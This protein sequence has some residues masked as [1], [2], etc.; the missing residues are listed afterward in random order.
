MVFGAKTVAQLVKQVTD[1]ASMTK[2]EAAGNASIRM[3]SAEALE[4]LCEALKTHKC[5]KQVVLSE[6]EITDDGC[7]FLAQLLKEN[8]VIEELVLDKNKIQSAGAK[9]LADALTKNQGLR[10]LNLMQQAVNNFGEDTLECYITMFNDNVTLTKISWRLESRK[11]FMLNKLQTRNVE[12]KKRQDKGADYDS[13]LPDH[14]KKGVAASPTVE[15]VKEDSAVK[16]DSPVKAEA[17]SPGPPDLPRRRPSMEDMEK[18][19]EA[20]EAE[21]G[22]LPEGSP[23]PSDDEK[24]ADKS[25]GYTAEEEPAPVCLEEPAADPAADAP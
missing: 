25:E 6:C 19:I 17:S 9:T 1:D 16:E 8:H 20:V 11:S 2:F 21:V 18:H 4:K 22:E 24:P 12:I 7:V 13:F 10:T 3:K 23:Q 15:P 14:M 5:I